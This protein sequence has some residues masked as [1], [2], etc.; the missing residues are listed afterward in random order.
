MEPGFAN[1]A[2]ARAGQ[3]L[4]RDRGG[5]IRAPHDGVVILPLYQAL[6]SD[7]YFWGRAHPS[8]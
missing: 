4:A 5:E 3:L 1:L 6:G 7:G 2:P 8:G